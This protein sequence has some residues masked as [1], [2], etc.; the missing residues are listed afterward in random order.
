MELQ[1]LKLVLLDGD[2]TRLAAKL[3][4]KDGPV[5][6]VKLAVETGTVS[7]SG[8][9][10]KLLVKIPFTT[11]WEPSV[12][13]SEVRIK[14]ASVKVIGLPA[15]ILSGVF[16]NAFRKAAQRVPGVR[17]DEDVLSLDL[18]AILAARGLPARVR[19]KEVRCEPG[20]L[21]LEG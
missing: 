3:L 20:K 17:L 8:S 18:E 14:L 4:P 5:R 2:L 12:H 1:A 15:G 11:I 10:P 16:L 7:L 9:Y 13:G 21:T 6:N 19:L